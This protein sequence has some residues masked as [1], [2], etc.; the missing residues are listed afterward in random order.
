MLRL[1]FEG[2]VPLPLLVL[3]GLALAAV[4]FTLAIVCVA[5]ELAILRVRTARLALLEGGGAGLGA[6]AQAARRLH[7]L[8]LFTRAGESCA[9]LALGLIVV[10]ELGGA[11]AAPFGGPTNQTAEFAAG[12]L[13]FLFLLV[14]AVL[15]G[16]QVPRAL[17]AAHPAA[18]LH[19]LE[20]LLRQMAHL[21]R[22]LTALIERSER[23]LLG[24]FGLSPAYER[25]G[26]H[27]QADL[28]VMLSTSG[29]RGVLD[30]VEQD[31]AAA[32][33]EFGALSVS[34]IMVPRVD[35][36]ALPDG[37]SLS[38]ARLFAISSGH[39]WFPVYHGN[40]DDIRGVIEWRSLFFDERPDWVER[41]VPA[42]FLPKT[43][44]ASSA[45]ARMRDEGIEMAIALDE[46]GGTAGL[47]T[48]RT[49]FEELTRTGP[50]FAPGMEI[51]GRTPLRIA[52]SLLEAEL[53]DENQ[54]A[55]IGGL[56]TA[57][58]GRLAVVGDQVLM[59]GWLF[60]VTRATR[61]SVAMIRVTTHAEIPEADD[62]EEQPD[63]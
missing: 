46:H 12:S 13:V 37:Y 57:R 1:M 17:V 30:P 2:A 35:I 24:L 44:P 10:P 33:L 55:T 42:F 9:L 14:I 43:M 45:L 15:V 25:E 19:A 27:S 54:I 63:L 51:S 5:G 39:D 29:A 49:L 36:S 21:A 7:I 56:L 52:E 47:V 62:D 40:R 60:E 22:P 4:L 16:Q 53:G 61:S 48:G 23:V 59:S 41:I 28:Q 8:L 58:L 50:M 38:E 34:D 18:T 3:G 32:S 26:A 31:L 20:P 6:S 11:L